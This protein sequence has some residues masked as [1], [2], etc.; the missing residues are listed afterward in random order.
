MGKMINEKK[1]Q[2]REQPVNLTL[3]SPGILEDIKI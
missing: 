1:R 2:E 3:K